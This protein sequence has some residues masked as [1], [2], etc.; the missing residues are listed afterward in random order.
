LP[1]GIFIVLLL[2][3]AIFYKK[4]RVY[5]FLCASLLYLLS[6]KAVGNF[7][8]LPFEAPYNHKHVPKTVDAMVILSG[9]T[10]GK[11]ANL[12]LGTSSF[13]RVV[14][15]VMIAKKENLPII[16]SGQGLKEYSESM[17][18]R[19]TV[20]ELNYYFDINLTESENLLKNKFSILYENRSLN[21]Y[22]NA[23]YTKKLFSQLGVKNPSIYLVTSAFHL[24][25]SI[26]LYKHFGFA[27]TPIATDFMT[28]NKL[29]IS[30]YFPTTIGLQMSYHA[31]HEYAGLMHLSLK[32]K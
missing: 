27:I 1:P 31:L 14:Y 24:R 10:Y 23:K 20:S 32:L 11:S 21:T 18:M 19:D 2:L 3:G 12:T 7:L 13:K 29:N 28:T 17:S 25:R 22:E 4:A 8:L 26:K 6:T 30:Y 5:L 15:G 9:G 16:F